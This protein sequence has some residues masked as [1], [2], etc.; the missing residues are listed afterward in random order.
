MATI[1]SNQFNNNPVGKFTKSIMENV[2]GM[3]TTKVTI[4]E[5]YK[6]RIILYWFDNEF[7]INKKNPQSIAAEINPKKIE[8]T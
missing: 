8:S 2:D 3:E 4:A 6:P 7:L 5:K 1:S